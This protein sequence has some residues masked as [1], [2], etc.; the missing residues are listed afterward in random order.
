MVETYDVGSLPL[1]GK[2]PLAGNSEK[3]CA[4]AKSFSSI[5]KYLYT[6]DY[7]SFTTT[8]VQGFLDKLKAGVGIPNYPQFRDMNEMFLERIDGIEKAGSA[9]HM[10]GV[11]SVSNENA[12]ITEVSVIKERSK[13]IYETMGQPYRLK[14]CI[15]GPFTLASLFSE[16]RADAY[17]KLGDALAKIVDANVFNNKYGSVELVAVDEPTLGF[18][19]DSALD[20]G[21]EGREAL[22]KAWDKIMSRANSHGSKAIIHLHNTSNNLFWDV[23]NLHVIES[24]V[25]D[26]LYRSEKTKKRLEETDKFLKAPLAVTQFDNLILRTGIGLEEAAEVWNKIRKRETDPVEFLENSDTMKQRLVELQK[27]FGEERIPYAG[28]ECG[29]GSHP[30]YECAIEYLRRLTK[31]VAITKD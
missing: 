18:V 20:Y 26:P 25:G 30:S 10:A 29:L 11:P 6:A 2:L 15:T 8:I 14:V 27:R 4:C 28:L 17:L 23:K 13:D 7:D 12:K 24:H 16:R 19:D 21:S 3:Y 31:A 22:L 9:Y 1:A 5:M